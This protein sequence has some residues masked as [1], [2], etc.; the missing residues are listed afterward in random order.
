MTNPERWL[1]V[2][3][4]RF[5][6]SFAG[7]ERYPDAITQA[8]SAASAPAQASRFSSSVNGTPLL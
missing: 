4:E 2:E 7:F 5:E 3:P 6:T 8:T 1:A